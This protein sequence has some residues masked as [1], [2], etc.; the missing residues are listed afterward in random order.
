MTESLVDE[1]E[2]CD[3]IVGLEAD[4]GDEV[5]YDDALYVSE[6]EDTEH[7]PVDLKDAV[8]FLRLVFFLQNGKTE[9]NEQVAPAP[10]GKVAA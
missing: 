5:D 3:G 10:E 8:L 4:F 1:L 2:V 9:G 7:A 6:S